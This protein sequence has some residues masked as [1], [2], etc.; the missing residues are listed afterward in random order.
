MSFAQN[1]FLNNY[2]IVLDT[3]AAVPS[4]KFV[5]YLITEMDV[6]GERDFVLDF[7]TFEF[8][9]RRV[10]LDIIYY[11]SLNMQKIANCFLQ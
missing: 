3:N 7:V 10:S 9:M 8:K 1:L 2:P 4:T 11:N 5:N 6:M